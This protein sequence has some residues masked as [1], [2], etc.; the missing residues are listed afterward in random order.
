[1]WILPAWTSFAF[2][3]IAF[4]GFYLLCS[5]ML[6]AC[7]LS[8]PGN[9]WP[10]ASWPEASL[11][12]S[13]AIDPLAK[14]LGNGVSRAWLYP[15]APC[16]PTYTTK[17]FGFNGRIR[18]MGLLVRDDDPLFLFTRICLP[19]CSWSFSILFHSLPTIYIKITCRKKKKIAEIWPILTWKKNPVVGLYNY[20]L[21][22]GAV[23]KLLCD[24]FQKTFRLIKNSLLSAYC[25]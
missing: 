20:I 9:K 23:L 14:V 13:E 6:L 24:A 15:F 18:N 8:L 7:Q 25:V 12:F 19:K 5:F 11:D 2:W 4:W 16:L 10:D 3:D 1:M 22:S 17:A 21:R